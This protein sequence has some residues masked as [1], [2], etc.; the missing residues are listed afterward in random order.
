M[1]MKKCIIL[2]ALLLSLLGSVLAQEETTGSSSEYGPAAG[3]FSGAVLF[4]KGSFLQTPSAPSTPN[5]WWSVSGQA[6]YLSTIEAGENEVTNMLGVEGRYFFTDVI[7]LKLSGGALFRKTPARDNIPGNIDPSAPNAAW[8]P[9]YDAVE[10][11]STVDF[12]FNIGGE[13]H[14]P[15][16]KFDRIFPFVGANIPLIYG[17]TT[18][19]DPT[20]LGSDPDTF[21]PGGSSVTVVDVGLRH[22]E[23]YGFG[24]QAVAGV[25]YY[26][27]KGVYCG[28][29]FKPISYVYTYSRKMPAPGLEMLEADTHTTTFFSQIYFKVGFRF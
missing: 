16:K 11:N 26:L 4:G 29:E 3:D 19:Y 24:I 22:G 1:N 28:F 10:L 27:G 23:V 17:R 6:P 18:Q 14:F 12:N 21:E 2:S 9:A 15:S 13:Y 8:L 25:D 5:P 20:I 7:A